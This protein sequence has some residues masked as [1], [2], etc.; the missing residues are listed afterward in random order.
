MN[1]IKVKSVKI[2]KVEKLEDFE[3]EYVYDIGVD[4]ETPYFFANNILVHNSGYFTAEPMLKNNPDLAYIF[5][6]KETL[7]GLYDTIADQT[8]DSFA[9]F[10]DKTF[11]TGLERGSI[12]KA[13]RELVASKGL[14]ITKKRYALLYYDK[15][16]TRMDVDGKPGKIKA[17]G[18]DLKRSDTPKLMQI[19]LEDLLMKLLCG[20][21]EEEI[22][23]M[24]KVFRTEFR[25]R[26]G[27]EKGTPKRVNGL[28][29]Y[30]NRIDALNNSDPFKVKVKKD[31][32][33]KRENTMVPGHVQ[34]S[35]NWN[36]LRQMN[37]DNYS[38]EI[39]DGQKVIVCRLRANP[40]KMDSVAYPIDQTYLPD[41]YKNLPFDH[42]TMENTI[43]DKKVNN[44]IG[45]LK[46]DLRNTREDTTFNDL[47]AF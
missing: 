9:D 23:E 14:F 16:G 45:I 46:W 34:A 33:D 19:F 36:T 27:W 41:W 47:F 38:L 15:E 13:G 35:L 26:P 44:L 10:M 21:S 42:E 22:I 32:K 31:K 8:N 20:G 6:S 2:S 25:E 24:I 3:D 1:Q 30:S 40:L 43:I 39:T 28:S 29:N 12:I 37:S 4:D 7:I 18:L 11:N 17:M 5:E